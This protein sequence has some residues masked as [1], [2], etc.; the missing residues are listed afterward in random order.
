MGINYNPKIVTNGLVCYLDAANPKSYPKSGTNCYDLSGNGN[1][2]LLINNTSYEDYNGGRFSFSSPSWISVTGNA[3]L[4]INADITLLAWIYK[5]SGTGMIISRFTRY[6]LFGDGRYWYWSSSTSDWVN[7]YSSVSVPFNTWVQLGVSHTPGSSDAPLIY[8]NAVS[9]IATGTTPTP[10]N[11]GS[12][13]SLNIGEY[14]GYQPYSQFNGKIGIIKIY[15]RVLSGSEIRQNFNA[16]KGR[17][18]V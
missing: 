7:Y 4:N 8:I 13:S 9:N 10:T 11:S 5:I 12:G 18:D 2:G 3:T 15:N 6:G 16:T 1:N 14:S 17:Y